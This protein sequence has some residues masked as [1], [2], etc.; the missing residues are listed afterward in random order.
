MKIDAQ[1]TT[2]MEAKADTKL[3]RIDK[4]ATWG[5]FWGSWGAGSAPGALPA[6]VTGTLG[7]PFWPKM[8][9]Q[10]RILGPMEIRKG[11]QNHDF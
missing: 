9:V 10:G 3:N 11:S 8:E 7:R 1:K 2:Q 5:G 6:G 4:N